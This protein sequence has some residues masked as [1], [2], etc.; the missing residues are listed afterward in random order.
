[1][2]S[3]KDQ[4]N[5]CFSEAWGGESLSFYMKT[6]IEVFTDF[7]LY[8]LPV[9]LKRP[10]LRRPLYLLNTFQNF[11]LQFCSFFYL[12]GLVFKLHFQGLFV[13][14]SDAVCFP[15]CCSPGFCLSLASVEGVCEHDTV[16]PPGVLLPDTSHR[17]T[18]LRDGLT[19]PN[20][21][22]RGPLAWPPRVIDVCV[23]AAGILAFALPSP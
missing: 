4:R 23:A 10:L 18:T 15:R 6:A 3:S 2:R 22:P 7:P 8:F 12:Y 21:S 5:A 16:K 14:V 19:A 17:V 20:F 1:M 9:I 13:Y 11:C